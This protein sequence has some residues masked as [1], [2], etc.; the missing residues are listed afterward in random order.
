MKRDYYE[1]LGID[2]NATDEEIKRA[3]RKLAFE[4]HPD[5]NH[6]DGAES[7][8]KEINEAYEVLSDS[9][10]R[11]AYDRFGH[12]GEDVFTRGF[13]GFDFG[14]F[15]DIFDAFFGGAA[16]ATQRV[17]KRGTDIHYEMPL[18]FEEAVFGC[19]KEF[20]I[21]RIE[22]CSLCH[23]TGNEPGS[24]PA[25]CPNCNG[26]GQIRRVQQ[27]IFG[28]FT[29]ISVC[30][31]CHGEGTVITNPCPQC[32]GAGK[33]K[34]ERTLSVKIPAGVD[35]GSQIRLKGEG[36]AG[37]M[38]GSPGNVFITLGVEPHEFFIR[39]GD[40]IHYKLSINFA[41]AALGVMMDIPTLEGTTKL[42]IPA[43][44]QTDCVF[45]LKGKGVPRLNGGGRGD[46]LI[47]AVVVTPEKLT[48]EQKH[49]FEQLE[50]SFGSNTGKDK[51]K[52]KGF[53]R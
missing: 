21:N 35:N 27:S 14:G 7:M 42:N 10:K 45:R 3:F 19:E 53:F 37:E 36:N 47:T 52:R 29:N 32:K 51:N 46:Q 44:T 41:E 12:A 34:C 30:G 8:F 40:D 28:R 48:E 15:G 17:P 4:C 23:G 6:D 24:Q 11:A 1:V 38:G 25:R 2:R 22:N 9:S 13:E 31:N 18:S 26:T 49:L 20:S 50:K 33:E 39:D 43:G 5:R 16:T